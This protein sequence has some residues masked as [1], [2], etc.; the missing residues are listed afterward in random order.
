MLDRTLSNWFPLASLCPSLSYRTKVSLPT[1][2][3]LV[4]EGSIEMLCGVKASSA[5]HDGLQRSAGLSLVCT[6]FLWYLEI[7]CIRKCF[8][9]SWRGCPAII[10]LY[11]S[12]R[13][14]EIISEH[15]YW[16]AH[17]RQPWGIQHPL[18]GHCIHKNT[19]TGW[20]DG[21]LSNLTQGYIFHLLYFLF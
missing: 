20:K 11:N 5:R 15:P 19:P 17:Q 13:G 21:S 18:C 6:V 3:G 7:L 1:P 14:L 2:M 4:W 12:I 9:C 10:S 16:A 8:L